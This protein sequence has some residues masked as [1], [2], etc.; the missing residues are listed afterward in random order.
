MYIIKMYAG[1]LTVAAI[2]LIMGGLTVIVSKIFGIV[3]KKHID[4]TY[5]GIGVFLA[6]LWIITNSVLRQVIFPNLSIADDTPFLMVMLLPFPFI[7]FMDKIQSERYSKLYFGAEIIM[8]AIDITCCGLY[9]A[10]V[11]E[12]VNVFMYVAI[13]CLL[14]IG[15]VVVTFIIDMVKGR[16]KE[17]KYVA[18]G[19]F[20]AIVAASAQILIYFNRTGIFRGTI[21]ASG[22]L[23]LLCG[24]AIH[25][26]NNL[27]SI[28]R[29]KTA[30]E[31]ANEAKGRFL[32]KMSHEIRTPINAVLGMDEMILR[33]SKELAIREYA[34]DIQS[35][36]KSLLSII[37]DILDISKIESGKM[38]IIPVEYDFSSMIHDTVNMIM[39]KATLNEIVTASTY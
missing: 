25:T 6:A 28:E 33:E 32:A 23:F 8:A 4:I 39:I 10:G 11:R 20:G 22:L 34:L 24:A 35:A 12:L 13:G 16:I 26:V 7:I 5:L 2:T 17:Y 30:A 1:E 27:F 18:I 14:S 19:L 36:G 9:I 21:L 31:L 3:K 29:D 38:E 37:N 15:S